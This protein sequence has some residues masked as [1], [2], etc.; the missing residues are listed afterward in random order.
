MGGS[1]TV[2]GRYMAVSY[3]YLS[4]SYYPVQVRPYLVREIYELC[5]SYAYE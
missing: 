2:I 1:G 5:A 4:G 3:Q